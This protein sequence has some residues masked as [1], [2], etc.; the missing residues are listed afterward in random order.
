MCAVLIAVAGC[1][2]FADV[3][4]AG[5]FAEVLVLLLFTGVD[6]VSHMLAR[7][8]AGD[9]G[10]VVLLGVLWCLLELFVCWLK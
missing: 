5:C 2:L 10:D 9:D 8:T 4:F 1:W 6:D 7:A 3:V